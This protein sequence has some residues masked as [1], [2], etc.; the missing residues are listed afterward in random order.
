MRTTRTLTT[1]L[2]AAAATVALVTYA[3]W[4]RRR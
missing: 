4:R 1:V 3:I 2:V